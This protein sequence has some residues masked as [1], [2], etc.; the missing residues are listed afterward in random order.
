MKLAVI[1]G[2]SAGIGR[3]NAEQFLSEGW[4]VLNLSRRPCRVHGVD[5]LLGDLS[6]CAHTE[7]F[8]EELADAA[9]D[10]EQICLIHNAARNEKDSVSDV[11]YAQ[12]D[13]VLRLNV[14]VPSSLN[15]ILIPLMKNGSS[16]LY[17]GSTLSEKAVAGAF[18]Y[19]GSKHAL[20]GMMRATCQDL[21]GRGIHTA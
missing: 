13:A 1:T 18:S 12:L 6:Q 15:Q 5:N 21:A 16:V 14:S 2:A 11:D 4:K 10:A 7:A 9:S 3:A 17:I 8:A 19:V 20:L